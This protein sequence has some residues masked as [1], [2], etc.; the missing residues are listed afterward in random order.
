MCFVGHVAIMDYYE[1]FLFKIRFVPISHFEYII[2]ASHKD[3]AAAVVF[4]CLWSH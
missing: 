4:L 3:F 2:T 1:V